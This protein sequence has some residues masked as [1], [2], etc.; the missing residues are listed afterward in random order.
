[1][2][3]PLLPALGPDGLLILLVKPQFEAGREKVGKGGVVKDEDIHDEVIDD[4]KSF[5]TSKGLVCLGVTRSPIEGRKGN[6]EYFV[7]FN[8]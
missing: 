3:P 1:M 4:I 7:A 5:F 2:I 8:T 6:V